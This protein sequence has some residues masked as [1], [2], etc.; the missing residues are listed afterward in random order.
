M[1]MKNLIKTQFFNIF[2]Y[3][4]KETSVEMSNF[5]NFNNSFNCVFISLIF[6]KFIYKK[7]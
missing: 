6:F 3:I 7:T 5:K 1:L 4:I 2:N